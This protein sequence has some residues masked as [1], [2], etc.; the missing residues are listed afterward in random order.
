[1][2]HNC[3]VCL[4]EMPKDREGW[5]QVCPKCTRIA[6]AEWCLSRIEECKLIMSIDPKTQKYTFNDHAEIHLNVL[7]RIKELLKKINE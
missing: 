7:N 3:R 6:E 5:E 1:M 4:G 2:S